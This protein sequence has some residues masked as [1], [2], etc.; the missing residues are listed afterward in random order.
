MKVEQIQHRTPLC[1]RSHT[2]IEII[3]MQE[4]YL[5]QLEFIPKLKK[6]AK[7]MDFHPEMHRQILLNWMNSLTTDYPIS[8]RRY[9]ATE[10]P[11]WYCSKCNEPHLPK[12]GKYYRPWRDPAPFKKCK[13]CGNTKFVGETKTFDTWMDSSIS[14]LLHNEVDEEPALPPGHLSDHHPDPGQGHR[15]DLAV[16]FPPEMLSAHRQG[17]LQ[18]RL[19]RRSGAGRAGAGDEEE[20]RQLRGP[21]AAPAEVRDRHLPILGR[22]RRQTW[23]TTSG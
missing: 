8:R 21:G 12:P 4:F 11:I 10:I 13:K 3:P 7:E 14:A 23:A 20:L 18:A 15:Q 5:K 1:E 22:R 9:Y 16:L 19:G 2:P 6:L 17:A